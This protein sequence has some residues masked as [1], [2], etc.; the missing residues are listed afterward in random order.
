MAIAENL[1]IS[2]VA[3]IQQEYPEHV[4]CGMM[5]FIQQDPDTLEPMPGSQGLPGSQQSSQVNAIILAQY[6]TLCSS[7]PSACTAFCHAT[8]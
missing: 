6:H 1:I 8:R 4:A 2:Q 3:S 7:N 5:S